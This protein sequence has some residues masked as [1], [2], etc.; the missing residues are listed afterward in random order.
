MFSVD[1]YQFSYDGITYEYDGGVA[2]RIY[3]IKKLLESNVY[4]EEYGKFSLLCI[5]EFEQNNG[6]FEV[7]YQNG[8]AVVTHKTEGEYDISLTAAAASRLLLAG[9]GHTAQ[10]AQY[11]DGV[12]INGNA[13]A[14]FKAFPFRATRFIDSSWSI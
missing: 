6:I 11:I 9:E 7:E 12:K 2:G 10:T 8:K 14:F 13:D 5:D 3:N 1:V 4:P